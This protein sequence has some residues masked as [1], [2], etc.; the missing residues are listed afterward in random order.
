SLRSEY[1]LLNKNKKSKTADNIVSTDNTGMVAYSFMQNGIE[2]GYAYNFVFADALFISAIASTGL[3]HT[4]TAYQVEGNKYAFHKW[5]ILPSA[6]VDLSF[7]YNGDRYVA[8]FHLLYRQRS[9]H[10]QDIE[11]NVND[12][13]LHFTCGFRLYAPHIRRRLDQYGARF[14]QYFVPVR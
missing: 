9:I 11:M 1:I 8:A 10:A 3:A 6:N 4:K 5:Q 14:A 13:S 2:A 12:W 7:G